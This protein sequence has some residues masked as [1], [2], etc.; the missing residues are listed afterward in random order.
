MS[1]TTRALDQQLRHIVV[2][3]LNARGFTSDRSRTLCRAMPAVTR[4][5]R[6]LFV[7]MLFDSVDRWWPV[8]SADL[9]TRHSLELVM[10]LLG[11]YGLPWLDRQ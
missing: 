1:E 8:S 5:R 9:I 6:I 10:D 7:G 2:P 3:M 11:K 4:L